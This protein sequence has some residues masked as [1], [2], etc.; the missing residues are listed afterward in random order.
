M[1]EK[2]SR[3]LMILEVAKGNRCAICSGKDDRCAVVKQENCILGEAFDE[4]MSALR[5]VNGEKET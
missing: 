1:T 2:L 5:E 3:T 4:A